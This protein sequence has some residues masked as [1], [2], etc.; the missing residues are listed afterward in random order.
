M[1]HSF[2]MMT[3]LLLAQTAAPED[4]GKSC[5][6]KNGVQSG[7][8]TRTVTL[9][10]GTTETRTTSWWSWRGS[11]ST[12]SSTAPT[13][14]PASAV[15]AN[16]GPLNTGTTTATDSGWRPVNSPQGSWIDNRPVLSR[17]KGWFNRGDNTNTNMRTERM[18]PVP[19]PMR[20][21]VIIE[22]AAIAPESF[23]RLPT[24][25]EPPLGTPVPMPAAPRNT[26]PTPIRP[27]PVAPSSDNPPIIEIEPISFRPAGQTRGVVTAAVVQPIHN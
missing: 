20:G 19:G 17:I 12:T 5:P 22:P 11:A 15:P 1:G 8:Q 16:A 18:E 2:T 13:P 23:R 6:C 7:S 14:V 27:V 10:D 21:E 25:N 26:A 3:A 9:P 24:T 4:N